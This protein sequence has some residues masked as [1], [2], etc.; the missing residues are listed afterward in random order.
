MICRPPKSHKLPGHM[1]T[2]HGEIHFSQVCT[3]LK[4]RFIR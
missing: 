3:R 2:G 4:I 1:L